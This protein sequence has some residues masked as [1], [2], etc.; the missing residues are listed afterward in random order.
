[1]I[2]PTHDTTANPLALAS[3]PPLHDAVHEMD[4]RL[5]DVTNLPI[6]TVETRRDHVPTGER[7]VL[8]FTGDAALRLGRALVGGQGKL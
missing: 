6:L 4:F 3:D 2:A 1:M 8:R 5:D 7:I